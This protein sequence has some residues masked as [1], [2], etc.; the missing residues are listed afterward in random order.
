MGKM[1]RSLT[2]PFGLLQLPRET[3]CIPAAIRER[4]SLTGNGSGDVCHRTGNPRSAGIRRYGQA[5]PR[6]NDQE[7]IYLGSMEL[8]VASTS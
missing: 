1:G 3:S 4:D 5:C 8:R 2:R 7:H 6:L